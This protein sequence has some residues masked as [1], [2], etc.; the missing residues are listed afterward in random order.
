M[1]AAIAEVGV[2]EDN[3]A[4]ASLLHRLRGFHDLAADSTTAAKDEFDAVL[5]SLWTEAV[6][7]ELNQLAAAG[8]PSPESSER[9]RV[10]YE[11]LRRLKA[12]PTGS[13]P[14]KTL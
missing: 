4:T 6:K 13:S 10:L 11:Q 1:D 3:P 14:A 2:L 7:D 5:R 8:D 9:Q 12:T